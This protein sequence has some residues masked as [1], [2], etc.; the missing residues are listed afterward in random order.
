MIIL[1]G[2]YG[3]LTTIGPTDKRYYGG[4]NANKAMGGSVLWKF[5]CS[6]GN[7]CEKPA[8][9]VTRWVRNGR[10]TAF[11]CG[12]IDN[13]LSKDKM[14]SATADKFN[15]YKHSAA[16]RGLAFNLSYEQFRNIVQKR[17]LYCGHQDSYERLSKDRT[18]VVWSV[19]IVGIDR[20]NN[21]IG[22]EEENCVPCCSRCNYAK[23]TFTQDEFINWIA[24]V[25]EHNISLDWLIKKFNTDKEFRN[26]MLVS[27]DVETVV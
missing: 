9:Q 18:T 8:N 7:I 22:Y 3:N 11:S 4:P 13:S 16:C 20:T 10:K 15:Q 2:I 26:R 27:N 12:C 21:T 14:K 19:K 25:T 17:C 23:K 5:Q 1:E 6:C 24:R